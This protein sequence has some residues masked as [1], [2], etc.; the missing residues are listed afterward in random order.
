MKLSEEIL[1]MIDETKE[2]P[3]EG[4]PKIGWWKDQEHLTLYHGTH[5]DNLHSVLKN[6]INRAREST[7]MISM[8][9]EPNTAHGYASMHGGE[10]NFRRAGSKAKHV[11]D[12]DR[13]FVVAKVPKDWIE[14]NSHPDKR[15]G[16]NIGDAAKRMRD[17]ELHKNFKGADSEYYGM[18]ELRFPHIPKEFIQGYMRK[19][20]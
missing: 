16:G 13:V 11:P 10:L 14:K 1:L 2:I 19:E 8:A 18:A 17:P 15:L 7:G 9:L 5:K 20:K 6:G 3:W 12:K 4:H